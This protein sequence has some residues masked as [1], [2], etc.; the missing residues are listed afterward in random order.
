MRYLITDIETTGLGLDS[1]FLCGVTKELNSNNF[2]IFT[3]PKELVEYYK[4]YDYIV[5]HNGCR[6]DIPYL[7]QYGFS[8]KI[9]DTLI[10]SKLA[11]PKENLLFYDSKNNI[12][13]NYVGSYSLRAFGYRLN[14]LKGNSEKD[15]KDYTKA[16]DELIEYCKQ[17]V[18]ITEKLFNVCNKQQLLPKNYNILLIEYITAFIMYNQE[19]YGFKF[20]LQKALELYSKWYKEF[21]FLE[22]NLTLQFGY[23]VKEGKFKPFK[24]QITRKNGK[25]P[26]TIV[27]DRTELQITRFNPKSRSQIAS[28]L[29]ELNVEFESYTP[30][31]N[32]NISTEYLE[33]IGYTDL[34]KYLKLTKDLGQ[35]YI[36]NKSLIKLCNQKD[37]RLHGYVDFLSCSTHRAS[38]SNPNL[39]QISKTK[40]MR[41][42]L[43]ADKDKVLVG[44]DFDQQEL[45]LLGYYL[46][47]FGNKDYIK[48]IALGTK[49][50]GNDIHT[51][52]QKLVGLPNRNM[53]KTLIYATLYGAGDLKIG[54]QLIG[55]DKLPEFEYSDKE[56]KTMK[57]KLLNKCS[58]NTKIYFYPLDK[59]TIIKFNDDLVMKALY[60]KQIKEKLLKNV[61]GLND[62]IN[63]LSN[64][65]KNNGY[66][67]SLDNRFISCPSQHKGLNYLLQSSGAIYMKWYLSFVYSQLN[68]KYK[69]NND[70]GFTA[71]I[72][73]AL[74]I[75]CKESIAKEVS[76]ILEE[77]CK[78]T[79]KYFNFTYP[80]V[81]KAIIGKDFYNIFI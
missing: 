18:L 80:I 50:K 26:I 70:Y 61:I 19:Q 59:T 10:D 6:F 48:A 51:L 46:E 12:P 9:R 23:Y 34:A 40:E 74:V 76:N 73:D 44:L 71:N 24:K 1:L 47:K 42:L 22:N 57:N 13:S 43:I 29:K 25:Y 53:A 72:H 56:Y 55:N 65:V 63:Y 3:N 60:G 5:F 37:S 45:M 20:D 7:M 15:F 41:E 62:L 64:E 66:I 28:K 58:Y 78:L 2:N 33:S 49:E 75:E 4:S 35:L 17:D 77:S 79:S 16:T 11:F 69:L 8:S 31:G 32:P 68:K 21:Q 67:T 38:H 81:G 39:S 30:N 14:C 27:G 54:I 36:G 52:N